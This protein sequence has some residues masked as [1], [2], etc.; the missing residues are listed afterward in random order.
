MSVA[1]DQPGRWDQQASRS[2]AAVA[3]QFWVNGMVYAAVVPRLP[4][5]RDRLAIDVATLGLILTIAGLAGLAGSALSGTAI[6]RFGT[7][8]CIIVATAFTLTILP[9]VGLARSAVLFTAA[10]IGL[11]V[12]DV[13][14]DISMN[15][16]GSRLSARRSKPVMNRLHGLWSLGTVLGGLV[17]VR[18][19]AAGV[20][21]WLHMAGISGLLA[22]TLAISGRFLL[23]T[24]EP[25]PEEPGLP[26][27]PDAPIGAGPVSPGPSRL[28]YGVVLGLLGGGAVTMELT[29]SDWASFRLADDLNVEDGLVGLGFVAFTAGM[30]TGRFAGDSVQSL[31]GPAKLVRYA[32]ALAASGLVLATVV[33]PRALERLGLD[34]INPAVL[35]ITGFYI[36]ALGVSVIFP[37]LYDRAAKA[38]GPPGRGLAALTAGTR[39]AGLA[40]PVV[41]GLLAD[42]ALTVG[43]A[44]AIVTLP[45]CV[46][47]MAGP[48]LLARVGA[49]ASPHGR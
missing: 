18:A 45:S 21:L 14:M 37:Q 43:T 10:L 20:P 27:S 42:S 5:I 41:V 11:A 49:V 4:D 19:T 31:I 2:L 12:F 15:I 34:G 30:V 7:R 13:V 47:T 33:P 39:I 48:A 46:V 36:A 6:N 23:T 35:S 22:V 40:A 24:D 1:V 44:L 17:A 32:A 29:A 38:P 3:A 16:Q 26:G 9:M 8:N 25:A 28:S